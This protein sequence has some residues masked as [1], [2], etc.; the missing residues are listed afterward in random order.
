MRQVIIL[1]LIISTVL[2]QENT[3]SIICESIDEFDDTRTLTSGRQILFKDGGDLKTQGMALVA[4]TQKEKNKYYLGSL[5]VYAVGLESNCVDKGSTLDI[6]LEN[7]EKIKLSSWN[8]FNCK[9]V[10]YFTLSDNHRK[11]FSQSKIKAVRYTEKKSREKMTSKN[12]ITEKNA[13]YLP[14]LI[15]EIDAV[16]SGDL[17]F[18]VCEF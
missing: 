2:T 1:L 11:N 12:E 15:K 13:N 8:K 6:I 14:D 7:G 3:T 5:I 18:R 4:V 17:T 16:N 10:S 9:G